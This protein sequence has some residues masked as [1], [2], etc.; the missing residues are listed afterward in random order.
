MKMET[1]GDTLRITGL[2]ELGAG[3]SNDV[4]DQARAALHE[5]HKNIEIDLSQ[6]SFLDSCGLGALIALHKTAC[7]RNGTVRLL[8][9]LPPVLQVLELTGLHRVFEIIK[10]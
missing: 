5:P 2:T 10:A 4:R 8:K 3:N 6:T 1:H 9:P 7:G